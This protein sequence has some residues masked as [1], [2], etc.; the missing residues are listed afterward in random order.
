MLCCLHNLDISSETVF[1]NAMLPTPSWYYFAM[2]CSLCHLDISTET[3]FCNAFL[4][5][6][7][8]YLDWDCILQC[9]SAHTNL[10]SRLRL[11]FA[12][13]FCSHQLD[14]STETVFCNAFLLTPTWYLDWDCIL[15]CISAHT[16]L[17]SRLRMYFAM[18]FCSHQLDISTETV[19]CNALRLTQSWY[20]DWNCILLCYAVH[21]ILI[22]RLR[23]YFAMLCCQHHFDISTKTVFFNA[24]LLTPFWY[25]DWDCILQ[26]YAA[27]TI[28]ISRLRLY[29]AMLRCLH[30]FDI[31]TEIVICNATLLTTSVTQA[32]PIRYPLHSSR[33]ECSGYG[34]GHAWV[35]EDECSGYGMGHAW[36]TVDELLTSF[37]YIDWD[38]ILE[39]FAAFIIL[40]SRMQ[41]YAAYAIL[42]SRLRLYLAMLCYSHNLD[43][44]TKTV[45]CYAMLPTSSWYHDWSCILQYYAVYTILISRVALYF[46]MLCC[47][48]N[49]DSL[50]ETVFDSTVFDISTDTV[51]CNAWCLHHIDIS[52]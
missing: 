52:A 47:L 38:C 2:L 32:W 24:T 46:A 22:N 40:K 4:L 30:H 1:Y 17:I 43:I 51:F 7:T 39:S 6:P 41:C 8:W 16:N 35:A 26:C 9:F 15:Q 18:I 36:V 20:L 12:M 49:L 23:L 42:I 10:I 14:I 33:D 28:L 44:S 21:A 11:Y 31:S 48:H 19:F 5:T 25:L 37:W 3:V 45:F 27:Y 13:L 50:T 34:M 29:F